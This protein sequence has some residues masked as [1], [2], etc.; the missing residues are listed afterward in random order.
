MIFFIDKTF[1][2]NIS[3]KLSKHTKPVINLYIKEGN[4]KQFLS[5]LPSAMFVE[6]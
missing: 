2:I 5:L 6:L 1:D 3:K 4:E